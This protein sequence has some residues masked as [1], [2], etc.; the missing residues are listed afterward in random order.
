MG[1]NDFLHYISNVKLSTVDVI[2]DEFLFNFRFVAHSHFSTGILS[3]KI[4]SEI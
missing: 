2:L 4:K 1:K 3:T